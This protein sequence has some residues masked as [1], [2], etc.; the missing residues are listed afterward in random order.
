MKPI[1]KIFVLIL[2]LFSKVS[3]GCYN[4]TRPLLK[5]GVADFDSPSMVPKGKEIDKKYM[6][7]QRENLL[8]HWNNDKDIKDYIDY[9]LTF[10]YLGDYK[11]ALEIFFKAHQLTP[12]D[13]SIA[14]NIGTTYEIL[15]KNDS[16]YFWINKAIQIN[17]E[18]HYGSEW[19][20][21]NILKIKMGKASGISSNN[22]IGTNFGEAVN[23]FSSMNDSVLKILGQSIYFQLNERMTFIKPKDSIIALL[24]FD[25]GNIT[26]ITQDLSTA[27]RNYSKAKEYGFAS[28]EMDLRYEYFSHKHDA[29]PGNPKHEF[30]KN[31]S[32]PANNNKIW[33]TSIAAVILGITVFVYKRMNNK[34]K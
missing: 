2:I 25:L 5:G 12:N 29:M 31:T 28:K 6:L 24:L 8:M 19:I 10:A 32:K 3:F 23:P 20:H 15:G 9:G 30:N 33:A 7:Q 34:R 11:K 18:S 21:L 14:A 4:E 26:A 13:Y 1:Y 17:P 27:L 22:L 16:A